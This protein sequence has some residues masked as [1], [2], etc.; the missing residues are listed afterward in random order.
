MSLVMGTHRHQWI[1]NLLWRVIWSGYQPLTPSRKSPAW[2]C[3]NK[4]FWPI[5]PKFVAFPPVIAP[6]PTKNPQKIDQIW[7]FEKGEKIWPCWSNTF[8]SQS[9]DTSLRG[10]RRGWGEAV[11]LLPL[12][13][14]CSD[15]ASTTL[16]GNKNLL[17]S[18]PLVGIE[19]SVLG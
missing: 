8:I 2:S 17:T 18:E 4:C 7:I 13:D 19:L 9:T 3:G 12:W 5:L 14:W 10:A 1:R 16:G 11:S 6:P 15:G